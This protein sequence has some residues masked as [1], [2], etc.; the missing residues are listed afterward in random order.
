VA[1]LPGAVL[2]QATAT[3]LA[4]V[5]RAPWFVDWFDWFD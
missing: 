3:A 5:V 4:G 1:S 2:I